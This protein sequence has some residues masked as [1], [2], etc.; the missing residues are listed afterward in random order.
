LVA[1]GLIVSG[2]SLAVSE[3]VTLS[4]LTLG[5]AGFFLL[6]LMITSWSSPGAF[7]GFWIW[8]HLEDLIRLVTQNFNVFFV[9]DFLLAALVLG[10]SIDRHRRRVPAQKNPIKI[11]LFLYGLM[12]FLQCFSPNI[13][14]FMVP[15]VGLH[16]KLLYIPLF[17]ISMA[18]F[19]SER[20]VRQFLVFI[21]IAVALE[22]ALALVQYFNDPSWWYKTMNLSEEA[23]VIGYRG[24][25]TGGGLL[26]TGSV[27]NN[28]GRFTQF[29]VVV[30]TVV[31]GSQMLFRGKLLL[32]FFWNLTIVIMF[33]GGVF[34]QSSRTVF[35]LFALCSVTVLLLHGRS[36]KTKLYALVLT[37][38]MIG[39]MNWITANVDVRIKNHY[40]ESLDPTFEQYDSIGGRIVRGR[41]QLNASL[42]Q[43]GL[44]GHG[45]GTSS[46]GRQHVKV[47]VDPTTG[48]MRGKE[49]G[50]A[51]LIWEFGPLGPILW[52][53]L[54]GTLLLRGWQTYRRVSH[55]AYSKLAFSIVVMIACA[56]IL[57]FIGLQ[58]LEN[59]LVVTHFWTF[60]GLLFALERITREQI[61]RRRSLEYPAQHYRLRAN[62]IQR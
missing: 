29:I 10:Y 42:I 50:Y 52:I 53:F 14:N 9:K 33:A 38:I 61:P 43:S 12:V 21:M 40:V 58:Y 62:Q 55:T 59:Y 27:F 44:T 25:E 22:S 3:E 36:T 11:P 6:F 4:L 18:Y 49:N 31:L 60:A 46:Q 5:M 7:L 35:Y 54:M 34:L 57:Q 23:E 56:F 19:D 13:P 45:T 16:A 48:A 20:K 1:G 39:V 15:L 2:L 28:P 30:S 17:Y 47:Y 37:F 8:I 51:A 41:A 24:Y 32:P 26:K